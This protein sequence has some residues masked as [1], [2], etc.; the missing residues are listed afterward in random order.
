L[1]P[2]ILDDLGLVPALRWL[3]ARQAERMGCAI[4]FDS[5]SAD[6]RYD[7]RIETTCFR[8]VQEA[9]NN[10]ARY[11]H[12]QRVQVTL[13]HLEGALQCTVQD[14]GVGFNV[15]AARERA[16]LGESLGL[17]SMQ[18]RVELVGGK[19]AIQSENGQGTAIHV[20]LPLAGAQS[21]LEVERRR[22]PR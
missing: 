18:E 10:I 17:L 6:I 3:L 13:V 19:F 5:G 20:W 7:R 8:V 4:Q 1:R 11:A 22:W 9:L 15:A 14:N 21:G 16:T 2:S 12:A